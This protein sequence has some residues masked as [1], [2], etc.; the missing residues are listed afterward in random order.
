MAVAFAGTHDNTTTADWEFSAPAE[1]VAFAKKYLDFQNGENFTRKCIRAAFSSVA[2]TAII[3]LQDWL[4]LG[5][6]ARM[7]TPSTLGNNW[8]WRV[9]GALVTDALAAEIYQLTHLYGR[10]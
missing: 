7:N 6:E 8:Q 10:I 2:D 1:D 5:K 9:D 3:P 4:T